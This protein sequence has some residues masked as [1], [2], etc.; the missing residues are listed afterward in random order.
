MDKYDVTKDAES[1]YTLFVNSTSFSVRSI[2]ILPI[3]KQWVLTVPKKL[4]VDNA[5]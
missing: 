5:F 4:S 3:C 2:V 1:E